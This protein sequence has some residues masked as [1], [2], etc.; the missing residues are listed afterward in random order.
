M[1]RERIE[2]K[3]AGCPWQRIAFK[4]RFD[5]Y[6]FRTRNEKISDGVKSYYQNCSPIMRKIIIVHETTRLLKKLRRQIN[7]TEKA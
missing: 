7:D 3:C 1:K 4:F 2:A 6:D 5:L